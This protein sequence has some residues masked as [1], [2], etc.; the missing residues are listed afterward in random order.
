MRWKFQ[1]GAA[2]SRDGHSST[3]SASV[4]NLVR[5]SEIEAEYTLGWVRIVLALTLFTSGLVVSTGAA[6]LTEPHR[7]ALVR[8][9]PMSAVL[10]LLLL[11]VISFILASGHWF[12]PWMAFALVSADAVFLGAGLY[13]GLER[14]GLG[15]NWIAA[16]PTIWVFPL[17]LAVGALRY[18]ALVQVWATLATMIA[19]FGVAWVLGFEPFLATEPGAFPPGL[20]TDLARLFSLPPYLMRAVLLALIGLIT[21]L[22][23]AR[24][25]RLLMRTVGETTR[26]ANLARFLPAEVAPLVGQDDLASDWRLGRR[27]PATVLFVDIRGFTAYAENMDPSRLSVFVSSFRRRVMRSAE[28]TGG[29]VDKFIGDG[30]MLVFGV[31]DPQTDDCMRAIACAERLLALVDQWNAKRHFDPPIRVGIGI[32]TGEVYCGL[33][34]DERRLEF[35][36]LGDV[37]NVAAKIEQATKRFGTAILASQAV[38]MRTDQPSR[39]HEVGH[40]PLGG[41]GEHLAIF[42]LSPNQAEP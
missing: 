42:A 41:R 5:E 26:R 15:G 24:S 10:A 34:G 13:F 4:E 32:H 22:A 9:M 36:V 7:L 31:P 21:A 16:I 1:S 19:V 35:T 29:V 11:G 18:R 23:M 30:A 8:F 37:V 27:Q 14:V 38:I 17:I 6:V 3:L 40:E 28:A 12:R 39:W 25:R 2:Q 20:E 33:V